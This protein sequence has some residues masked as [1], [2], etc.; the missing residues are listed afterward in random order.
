MFA[1]GL[2]DEISLT[3]KRNFTAKY[4]KLG[5]IKENFSVK[6]FFFLFFLL[7]SVGTTPV[8]NLWQE[9]S[10]F[11]ERGTFDGE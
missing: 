6:S 2:N 10:E 5:S 11:V 4:T 9:Q 7:I 8:G 3:V 1:S